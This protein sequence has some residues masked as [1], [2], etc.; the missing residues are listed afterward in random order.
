MKQDSQGNKLTDIERETRAEEAMEKGK[1]MEERIPKKC[2]R[3]CPRRLTPPHALLWAKKP[4]PPVFTVLL[5]TALLMGI[6]QS[7]EISLVFLAVRI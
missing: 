6:A 2:R 3:C 5:F 4:T 7:L 1:E